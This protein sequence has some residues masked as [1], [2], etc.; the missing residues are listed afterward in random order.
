MK[1]RGA[2]NKNN[3]ILSRG[4]NIVDLKFN[5]FLCKLFPSGSLIISWFNRMTVWIITGSRGSTASRTSH[6]VHIWADHGPNLCPYMGRSRAQSIFTQLTTSTSLSHTILPLPT[7]TSYALF[8]VLILGWFYAKAP[9]GEDGDTKREHKVSL[10][11]G[12]VTTQGLDDAMITPRHGLCHH[13][14]I[15]RHLIQTWL[16][17]R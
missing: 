13:W 1:D 17:T 8:L 10:W 9:T 15:W 14:Y 2:H 5:I 11:R 12:D 3:K 4:Y 6:Y 16:Q 7:T